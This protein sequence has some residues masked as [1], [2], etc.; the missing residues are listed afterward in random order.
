MLAYPQA[1]AKIE[2]APFIWSKIT[3][4]AK[5]KMAG[6]EEGKRYWTLVI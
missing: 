1:G 3:E 5:D 2:T 6:E 4:K